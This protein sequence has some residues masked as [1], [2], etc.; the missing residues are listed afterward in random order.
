MEAGEFPLS[1]WQLI[2]V[3]IGKQET[4]R[5]SKH[6]YQNPIQFQFFSI[7]AHQFQS[8]S[9]SNSFKSNSIQARFPIQPIRVQFYFNSN[10]FRSI[11]YFNSTIRFNSILEIEP[12]WIWCIPTSKQSDACLIFDT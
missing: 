10:Q 5:R 8:N 9:N 1:M 2:N 3:K 7:L 6:V 11:L 12:N 4:V